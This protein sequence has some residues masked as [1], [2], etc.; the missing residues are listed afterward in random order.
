[1]YIAPNSTIK[2]LKNV[3]L[4]NTYEHTLYFAPND[5]GDTEQYRYFSQK[6]KFILDHQSY[7][8]V[9]RGWMRINVKSDDLYDCNYLMFQNTNFGSKWFY[10]FI[11]TVEYINNSVSE[12][13]FELDVMQTWNHNY[14][15]KECFVEREHMAPNGKLPL[16]TDEGLSTGTLIY[17]NSA[18]VDMNDM[19]VVVIASPERPN[20]LDPTA[21]V[22]GHIYY[23]TYNAA[24]VSSIFPLT[25]GGLTDLDS[26]INQLTEKNQ[27][28]IAMYQYPR[29][30]ASAIEGHTETLTR[31]V[32]VP[33]Y[34]DGS[35]PYIPKNRKLLYYP[36]SFIRVSAHNGSY[37]D[38]AYEYFNSAQINFEI[39]CI[40]IPETN[41]VLYPLY[42]KNQNICY[43]EKMVVSDF[44]ICAW[45]TSSF[46][47]WW[48]NNKF[49]ILGNVTCQALQSNPMGIVTSAFKTLSS[50]HQAVDL[51]TKIG[52]NVT[53]GNVNAGLSKQY[54]KFY[55]MSIKRERARVIDDYFERYGYATQ[56]NK[57]PN[58]N[59]R[60]HWCYTKTNNC[61]ITGSVPADDMRKICQIYDNGITF[62][63]YGNEVGN[64]S[65]D[66]S[67]SEG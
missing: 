3:P 27:N 45:A 4:D 1:M 6:S 22:H 34:V 49:N 15:L 35:N 47:E 54:I 64:Y 11:N 31:Q 24:A 38:Y 5:T 53:T 8:R 43:E 16:F 59:V 67:V 63:K 51:P 65:L 62:W 37:N 56:L 25:Q 66:N 41:V 13:E 58:R 2:I 46:E 9:K 52:G 12:I 57:I 30:F 60:P 42:Y 18:N 20:A 7:Q 17:G 33:N 48:A 55:N 26:Y 44:P 21:G 14:D 28:I 10:A 40:N 19:N 32:S 23:N 29:I 39:K 36:F 61:S 50:I